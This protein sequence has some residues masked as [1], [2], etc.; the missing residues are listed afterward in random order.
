MTRRKRRWIIAVA[1]VSSILV[2]ALVVLTRLPAA[3]DEMV[4]APDFTLASLDGENITL[5]DLRGRY[6]L[7]NFWATW[8]APCLAEMTALQALADEHGDSLV[9]LG[10]NQREDLSAIEPF[11]QQL[12]VSFPILL[13]PDDATLIN[14]QVM[15]L[16]RSALVDPQGYIIYRAFGEVDIP[17]VASLLSE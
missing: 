5:S 2:I 13:N 3:N 6:V 12:G 15:G 4:P 1:A 8:C 10:I 17:A 7:I 11:L 9:I 14:Y 16:P